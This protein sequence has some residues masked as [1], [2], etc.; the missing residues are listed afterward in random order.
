MIRTISAA[1]VSDRR[2]LQHGVG[3]EQFDVE[4]RHI[5]EDL[6]GRRRRLEA[7]A[8]ELP[9]RRQ[10]LV[11]G[12]GQRGDD[13]DRRDADALGREGSRT[14]ADVERLLR[15]REDAARRTLQVDDGRW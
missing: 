9:L 2:A 10:G 6:V 13:I 4:R 15:Q 14:A 3:A 7:G 11:E 12:L 5:Q 8:F 1:W